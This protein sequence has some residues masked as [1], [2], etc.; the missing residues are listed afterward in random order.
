MDPTVE[1]VV[2]V[3]PSNENK[4]KNVRKSKQGI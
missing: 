1:F 3:I 2:E 4:K